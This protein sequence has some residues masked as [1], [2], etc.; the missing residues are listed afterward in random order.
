[1]EKPA[2][3]GLHTAWREKPTGRSHLSSDDPKGPSGFHRYCDL[4]HKCGAAV[5]LP[6]SNGP[7]PWERPS[8]VA[9]D[10]I[11]TPLRQ[12]IFVAAILFSQPGFA[13]KLV[14]PNAVAPEYREAALKRRAEQIRVLQ[15]NHKADEAKVLLRDRAE[16][17]N[18]CLEAAAEK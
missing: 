14:D 3:G 6:N 4:V 5:E 1:M 16:T 17:V 18:H 9:E 11:L 7:D 2:R 13:Q 12:L 10:F 15:C 8:E